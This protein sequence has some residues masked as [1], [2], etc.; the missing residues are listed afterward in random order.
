MNLTQA[1][2]VALPEI[3]AR[4]IA[5]RCPRLH[6]EVVHQEH[7]V[8]GRATVRVYVPGVDAIFNL[9]PQTWNVV[10]FFQGQDSYEEVAEAYSKETGY[11]ISVDELHEI[12]DDLESIEF[13]YKTPRERN[14]ALLMQTAEAQRNAGKKYNRWGDLGFVTFP[15]FDPDT[16]LIWLNGKIG[17]IFTWWFTLLTLGAFAVTLGIFFLH[18]GEISRD[19]LQ[20][21][22]F[23]DKSWLDL[24]AFWI[25]TF[26]LA[27][28]HET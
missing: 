13:W 4:L 5:Q 23:A 27:A 17:F 10:R 11:P 8:D 19:T 6:P 1:L 26:V 15:A 3:P 14:I 7:I 12:A 2:N 21:F 9:S 28:I 20:F 16:F 24:A 25:I 22:N 18:W